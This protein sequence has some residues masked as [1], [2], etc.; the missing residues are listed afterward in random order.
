MNEGTDHISLKAFWDAV[1]QR[2]AACSVDDLRAILRTMA[3]EALPSGRQAFLERLTIMPEAGVQPSNTVPQDVLLADIDDW[4]AEVGAQRRQAQQWEEQHGYDRGERYDDENSLGPYAEFVEPLIELF[5]RAEG[6]FDYGDLPLA[7]QA[8][9]KL[10]TEA[11]E[12]EDE[13]GRGV[14]A[15]DLNGIDMAKA[16]ACYLRAVYESEPAQR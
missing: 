2:L 7:G 10:F 9:Y 5:G 6:A 1:E 4:I 3:Q 12:L 11:L 16:R 15:E 13:Y 14:R 8:Y